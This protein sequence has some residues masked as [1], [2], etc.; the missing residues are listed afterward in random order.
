MLADTIYEHFKDIYHSKLPLP[1][2]AVVVNPSSTVSNVI[3]QISNSDVYDVFCLEG[4]SVYSTNVRALLSAS[5]ILD[6]IIRPYLYA[7]PFLKPTDTVN[8]ASNIMAHHRIRSAPIVQDNQIIGQVSAKDILEM[9]LSKDNKW[10]KANMIFTQNPITLNSTDSLGSARRIMTTKRIDHIPILNKGSVKQVLT[11]FHV[12]Q[13]IIP[14][15]RLGKKLIGVN[16]IRRQESSIG[17]IGSTRIPQCNPKD[18]LNSIIDGM[19]KSNT[20]CSLVSVWGT[21]HGIIAYRDILSLLA[22]KIESQIPFY[23]VGL[24][25]DS[26]NA[27][28]I[29]SKFTSTL[30]R[31]QKVYGDV[32]EARATIKR[33]HIKGGRQLHE[34]SIRITTPY[35]TF[36][37]SESG[38][39]LSQVFD[40][41]NKRFLRKL[42]RRAKQRFKPTIRKAE[43]PVSPI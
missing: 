10:I 29:I 43:L 19:L 24:P 4:N 30:K 8:K 22:A 41:L 5:N 16:K 33:Q 38:W 2:K 40:Y 27:D 32:I 23:I 3:K 20:T 13:T 18:D 15:E 37:H 31:I 34:V 17:N 9:L 42:S 25:E 6:A 11:S 36:M 35:K 7:V 28:I 26:P 21:L 1:Q 39:D 14:R 12:L